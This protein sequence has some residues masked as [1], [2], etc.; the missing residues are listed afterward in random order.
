MPD[1]DDYAVWRRIVKAVE[2]LLRVNPSGIVSAGPEIDFTAAH[3]RARLPAD[4]LAKAGL[5]GGSGLR[6]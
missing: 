4:A 1:L 5:P 3:D 2:E 6:P